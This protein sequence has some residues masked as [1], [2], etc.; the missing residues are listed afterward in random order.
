MEGRGRKTVYI[1]RGEEKGEKGGGGRGRKEVGAGVDDEDAAGGG[2]GGGG[3]CLLYDDDVLQLLYQLH[4]RL[5]T[6][7]ALSSSL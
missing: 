3:C 7:E 2:R 5:V 1:S 4:Y 6:S